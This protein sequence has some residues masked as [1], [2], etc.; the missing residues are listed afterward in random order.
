MNRLIPAAA[1]HLIA[2]LALAFAGVAAEPSRLTELCNTQPTSS[3]S[4]RVSPELMNEIAAVVADPQRN[5]DLY[6]RLWEPVT[7]STL[8]I[9]TAAFIGLSYDPRQDLTQIG[10]EISADPVLRSSGVQYVAEVGG[11]ACLTPPPDLVPITLTEYHNGILDHY[12]LSSS[13]QENAAIDSGAAGPAWVRT[14]EQFATVPADAC[15]GSRPVY[16]FY[17]PAAKSHVFTPD[18]QECGGVRKAGTGWLYEGIAFGAFM[19][20]NGE[21]PRGKTPI[22][23]LYNN[24][25]AH[26]DSNH[27]YVAK[28][29]LATEMQLRGWTL[30]GVAFCVNP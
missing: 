12:F 28:L 27:R 24:R 11:Y 21:C 16:R 14:G 25:A 13:N 8:I 20:T 7:A 1:A 4:I 18:P 10:A 5:P 9:G 23:R 3:A 22:W 15:H 6:R 26:G 17:G 2:G 19:P 30:E 29:S